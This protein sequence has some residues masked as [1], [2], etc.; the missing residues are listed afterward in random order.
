MFQTKFVWKSI[1][2]FLCP[3]ENRA[4]CEKMLEKN[5]RAGQVTDDNMTHA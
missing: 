5:C 4:V 1:T 3:L 2:H